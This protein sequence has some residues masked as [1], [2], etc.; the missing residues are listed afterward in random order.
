MLVRGG[1]RPLGPRPGT[2]WE[3]SRFAGPH[4]RDD[5]MDR[6][7]LVETLETATTWSNLE[8][9]YDAVRGALPGLHVG[10]HVSHL[11]PTGASLYFTLLGAPV[12]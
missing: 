4:L 1:A 12:R 3:R 10:C 2:R 11:Y 6:G 5:L 8:R 7:V 9:L